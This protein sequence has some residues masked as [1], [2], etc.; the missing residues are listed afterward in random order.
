MPVAAN[1]MARRHPSP[2]GR[3][4]EETNSPSR[5]CIIAAAHGAL[6][7]ENFKS[8]TWAEETSM[9]ELIESALGVKKVFCRTP[10][11]VGHRYAGEPTVWANSQGCTVFAGDFPEGERFMPSSVE[12]F[13]VR[14]SLAAFLLVSLNAGPN[15]TA[16]GVDGALYEPLRDDLF[17][18][19]ARS[20][21]PVRRE[22]W[23]YDGGRVTVAVWL[24]TS[25]WLRVAAEC[26][27]K[28]MRMV[29][30]LQR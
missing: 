18:L 5:A 22:L 11:I 29:Q 21:E 28:D 16:R 6:A 4:V 20:Y 15:V 9:G 8:P 3:N 24:K 10:E 17:L 23:K 2:R 19:W 7:A 25:E 26:R 30:G 1:T 27:A 12:K 14:P 13:W